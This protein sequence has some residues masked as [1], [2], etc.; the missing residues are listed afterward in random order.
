L[1]IRRPPKRRLRIA[2]SGPSKPGRMGSKAK[3]G[4]TPVEVAQRLEAG[5]S[6]AEI[7]HELGVVKSTVCYHVRRLGRAA[8]E[9]FARRYDWSAIQHYYDEGR[10]I[11]DCA[12][13]GFCTESWH[14]VVRAGPLTSRP[15]AAPIETYLVSG[16][17]TNRSHLKE[18]DCSSPRKRRQARQPA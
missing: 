13:L 2:R 18:L 4:V 6:I 16:R 12:I 10:S 1:P 3:P 15:A 14:R 8:D 17:K 7:A 9:R 5:K 11:R